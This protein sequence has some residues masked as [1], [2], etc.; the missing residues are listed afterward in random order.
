[1]NRARAQSLL[2]TPLL[3]HQSEGLVHPAWP[4][5]GCFP[6]EP[7]SIQ[8][9]GNSVAH[10]NLGLASVSLKIPRSGAFLSAVRR[11]CVAEGSG[12]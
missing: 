6:A 2:T 10:I 12:R 5:T 9:G 4:S 8:R 3:P 7:V 1:V 11:C